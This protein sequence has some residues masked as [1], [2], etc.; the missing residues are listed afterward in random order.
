MCPWRIPMVSNFD[1]YG[2]LVPLVQ[3]GYQE[4]DVSDIT[5]ENYNAYFKHFFYCFFTS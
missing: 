4:L 1:N 5:S 3:N 2:P